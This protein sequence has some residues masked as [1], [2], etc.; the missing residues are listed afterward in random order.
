MPSVLYSVRDG[1]AKMGPWKPVR[2]G[3]MA[4]VTEGI[5]CFQGSDSDRGKQRRTCVTGDGFPFSAA[6]DDDLGTGFLQCVL[7]D[8]S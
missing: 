1:S 4:V 2:S 7:A 8:G 5:S 6:D 3:D